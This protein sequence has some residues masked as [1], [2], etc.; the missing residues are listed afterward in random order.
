MAIIQDILGQIN[1]AVGSV[2]QSGFTQM[3][4]AA[5]NV[6]TIGG[7]V[8]IAAVGL[9]IVLQIAPLQTSASMLIF[10]R[11]SMISF[12]AQSWANFAVIFDILS[13]VPSSI[14]ASVAKLAGM[15]TSGGL[16]VVLDDMIVKFMAYGQ[17]VGDNA[18][19]LFGAVMGAFFFLIGCVFVA[20]AVGMLAL[21]SIGLTLMVVLAPLAITCSMFKLTTSLF[22]HWTK[23]LIG[24]AMFP[25]ITGG[26]L[27]V[28]LAVGG[29]I[30]D[31]AP[32]ADSVENMGAMVSF[33]VV[34]LL[35]SAMLAM[36]PSIASSLAGT[37]GLAGAALGAKAG[38]GAR[39]VG[40][41]AGQ[42]A[43]AGGKAALGVVKAP[44][45]AAQNA[46][47]VLKDTVAAAGVS[48]ATR[49]PSAGFAAADALREKRGV[50]SAALS[51]SNTQ[52]ARLRAA[53]QMPGMGKLDG[54]K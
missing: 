41:K 47:Q 5:G 25:L 38:Q 7:I 32:A 51:A 22:S 43:A 14:G 17:A 6:L 46:G 13:K 27:G 18:G 53:M 24:Y 37:G 8:V 23:Q 30:A 33:V 26:M 48:L 40:G 20:V 16:L 9:N 49:S 28:I 11:M 10:F 50:V 21:G 34:F 3:A 42:G 1:A 54:K 39:W 29:R 31:Q 12:F 15:N 4:G 19:Y 45:T 2:A 44:V 52:A 36:V 35:A